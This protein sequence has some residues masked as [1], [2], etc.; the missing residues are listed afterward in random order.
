[1]KKNLLYAVF[2][3]SLILNALTIFIIATQNP[4][5]VEGQMSWVD[6]YS[7]DSNATTK[8]L[9]DTLGI[10]TIGTNKPD[11]IADKDFDYKIIKADKAAFPLAGVMQITDTYKK[12]GMKPHST[13]YLTV[14]N[15][16]ESAA[17]LTANGA[18]AI[19]ENLEAKNMKFGFY[20]IPGGVEIGIVQY[21]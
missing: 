1:M 13:I 10:K 6:L 7:N 15:Y 12:E 16:D 18:K 14:K 5:K 8:F 11:N 2:A 9:N 4:M 21:N 19:V 20:T 3:V 17:K